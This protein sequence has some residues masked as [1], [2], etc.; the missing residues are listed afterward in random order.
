MLAERRDVT[1]QA[2]KM[3]AKLFSPGLMDPVRSGEKAC[4]PWC[5][6]PSSGFSLEAS[7]AANASEQ[8]RELRGRNAPFVLVATEDLL[9][10]TFHRRRDR[11]DLVGEAI[12]DCVEE[13][14]SVV[15]PSRTRS[16]SRRAWFS[17]V[18]T[19]FGVA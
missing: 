19:G 2:S 9:R 13:P 17:K 14:T 4:M 1:G 11:L 18:L 12:D 6:P 16:G 10:E 8:R 15:G 5:S 7:A 3:M